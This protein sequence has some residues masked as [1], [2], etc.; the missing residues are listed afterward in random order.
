MKF[1]IA[2]LALLCYGILALIPAYA[3]TQA[4]LTLVDNTGIPSGSKLQGDA[5]L[6]GGKDEKYLSFNGKKGCRAEFPIGP[7]FDDL[8]AVSLSFWFQLKTIP[9]EKERIVK[10]SDRATILSRNWSWR[11]SVMP[12]LAM[13]VTMAET[14]GETSIQGGNVETGIWVNGIVTYSAAENKFILYLDG[15]PVAKY[16]GKHPL[17]PLKKLAGPLLLG[18]D[19]TNYNSF[20]GD[21]AMVRIFP[22]I[23]S[24]AEISAIGAE[25]PNAVLASS[26]KELRQWQGILNQLDPGQLCPSAWKETVAVRQKIAAAIQG[27][28]AR[29]FRTVTEL[30]PQ[31]AGLLSYS[32]DIRQL[33]EWDAAL[34]KYPGDN[35]VV[36]AGLRHEIGQELEKKDVTSA[37]FVRRHAPIVSALLL[38][39]MP[40]KDTLC[41][42]VPPVGGAPITPDSRIDDRY[43]G[44]R[45]NLSMTPGEYEP[46][47]FVLHPVRK[48]TGVR[49]AVPLLEDGRG[50]TIPA[51]D[52]D[53]KIVQCWY[54]AGSAWRGVIQNVERRVLVPELLV[55]DPALVKVDRSKQM[56]YLRLSFPE[57]IKYIP[58]SNPEKREMRT[59]WE[60][61]MKTQEY[62]VRDAKTLQPVSIPANEN[63]QFVL[64]VKAPENIPPGRYTGNMAVS[65]EQGGLGVIKIAV[66][67][68][69]FKLAAPK[70]N[71]DL[72]RDLTP[73]L[74]YISV[75]DPE[76]KGD[77]T[78]FHRNREEYGNE[79]KNLRAHGILNPLCYQLQH[80]RDM[81]PW[82][83]DE[84]RNVLKMRADAGLSNRPLFLSGP[85]SN[86]Q[87][88]FSNTPQTL[89]RIR[90]E[91]K[92]ILDTVQEV[93]GHRDVYF[94]GVDETTGNKLQEERNIWQT[95]HDADG[96]VFVACNDLKGTNGKSCFDLVGDLLNLVIYSELPLRSEATKWHSKNNRIWSYDNP[97]GGVENP[98]VYRRNYGLL[99]YL[100]NYDGFATYCYYEAFGNPW[101]DF[102]HPVFRDHNFVY[103]TADGVVDTIAWEGYREAVDDIRYATTLREA[104]AAARK[105]GD[106]AKVQL[107]NAA[108]QW[109][110]NIDAEKADL[111]AVRTA[112]IR[113][114]LKLRQ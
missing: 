47:S 69:P 72:N 46:G 27:H 3:A 71:Y 66:T 75:L 32:R 73:S 114:I 14:H 61:S 42:Q 110:Q 58:V 78:P 51:E 38:D 20:T 63:Q 102:D 106:P 2:T 62:P 112:I 43:L 11:V 24:T 94:Y 44:N 103:P 18:E 30:K 105:S 84:L 12:S 99:L 68:L 22:R 41:Y 113:W 57:E 10:R 37:E 1:K 7:E 89:A 111:D 50:H 52:L 4:C 21:I 90:E 8:Q 29:T 48:L 101:D 53:L 59:R 86:L 92:K 17:A 33:Q 23:L 88:G 87:A 6:A 93:C 56:N 40:L 91:V 79:L 109:L 35:S 70:T 26:E 67:I 82:N 34:Q 54:Q 104:A 19:P 100:S 97:Q 96:K 107:A 5:K 98:D 85:E 45:M 28:D 74:Y 36:A 9:P 95:I 77:L 81:K 64:T 15:K 31:I 80:T 16:E 65:S 13:S 60:M 76:S 49:F 39:K 25:V 108:E 83:Q 55:N